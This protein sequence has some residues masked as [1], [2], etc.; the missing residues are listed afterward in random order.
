M[1]KNDIGTYETLSQATMFEGVLAS[2]PKKTLKRIRFRVSEGIQ[3]WST[4]IATWQTNELPVKSLA[5]SVNRLFIG[6]VVYTFLHPDAVDPI[7]K[8]L[9][10]KGIS[11]PVYWYPDV[12]A[13][14]DD[15]KF[16][17][18]VRV[19]YTASHDDAKRLGLRATVVSP[20]RAWS[21]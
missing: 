10:R 21:I 16:N 1:D 6:T 8:W 9:I 20:D 12:D 7:E 3:D 15:L 13:L 14:A 5:D 18:G 11:V 19:I 2:P 4:A 17:R